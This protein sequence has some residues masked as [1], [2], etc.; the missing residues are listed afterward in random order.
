[1]VIAHLKTF[2]SQ[3]VYRKNFKNTEHQET[4]TITQAIMK[5]QAT[6][7]DMVLKIKEDNVAMAN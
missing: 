6:Q 2:R 5:K 4:T 7:Q 3:T 1:M